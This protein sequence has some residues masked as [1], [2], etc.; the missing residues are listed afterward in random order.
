MARACRRVCVLR[1][2]GQNEEAERM[3]AE[4]VMSMVATLRGPTDSDAAVT[5]RLN[6]L[7]ATEAERVALFNSMVAYNGVYQIDGNKLILT[8]DNSH[9]QSWNGT[10]RPLTVEISGTLTCSAPTFASVDVFIEHRKGRAII[11]GGGFTDIEC[12]GTTPFSVTVNGFNGLFTGGKVSVQ[13]SAFACDPIGCTFA[14]AFADV[15]LTGKR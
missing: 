15:K 2:R 11:Q 14:D 9:I 6:S 1:E 4:E 7:F 12:D 5:D 13:A 3:R 8:I 10:Q